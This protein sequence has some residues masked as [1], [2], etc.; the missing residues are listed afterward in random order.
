MAYF[1]RLFGFEIHHLF[2]KEIVSGSGA[3]AVRTREFLANLGFDIEG[4]GNKIP[5]LLSSKVRVA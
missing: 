3:D 1:G 5:L 2:P 4:R